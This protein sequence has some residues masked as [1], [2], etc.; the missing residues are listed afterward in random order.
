MIEEAQQP[1][2]NTQVNQELEKILDNL[3]A[4]ETT[5]ELLEK[6]LSKILLMASSEPGAPA[7]D[8]PK[9]LV[10]LASDLSGIN[11][12]LINTWGFLKSIISRIEV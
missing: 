5:S 3:A 4:L 1:V 11:I 10:P 7:L 2:K 9:I 8:P 12:R 6:S